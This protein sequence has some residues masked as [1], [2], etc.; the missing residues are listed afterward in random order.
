MATQP[1]ELAEETI[2]EPETPAPRVR[3]PD[4]PYAWLFTAED[5]IWVSYWASTAAFTLEITGRRRDEGGEFRPFKFEIPVNSGDRQ[6][7]ST[8][9]RPGPGYLL[10]LVV[11]VQPGATY[12]QYGQVFVRVE[13]TYGTGDPTFVGR[14]LAGVLVQGSLGKNES[15]AW[16]GGKIDS[17]LDSPGVPLLFTGTAPA[18]GANAAESVPT[19]AIWKIDHTVIA[20]TTDAT[21][22]NRRPYFRIKSGSIFYG[23]LPHVNVLGAGATGTPFMWGTGYPPAVVLE[24]SIWSIGIPH[25]PHLRTG[26]ELRWTAINLQAGDQFG[27]PA[28][29]VREWIDTGFS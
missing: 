23:D 17:S 27:A 6:R 24:P 2:V 29:F 21:V 4:A 18:A 9:F 1:L 25:L 19:S 20:L 14:Q 8:P 3:F 16:P 13:A 10:S 22:A 15:R 28:I 7:H 5:L 26:I 12:V 11:A